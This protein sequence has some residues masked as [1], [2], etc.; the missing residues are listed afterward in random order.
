M[1]QTS[2]YDDIE[3]ETL[4]STVPGPIQVYR[5]DVDESRILFGSAEHFLIESFQKN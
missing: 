1:F 3:W 2:G 5:V 4:C